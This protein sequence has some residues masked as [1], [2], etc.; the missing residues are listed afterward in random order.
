V[1]RYRMKDGSMVNNPPAKTQEDLDKIEGPLSHADTTMR[2]VRILREDAPELI[3]INFQ[4]HPDCVGGELVSADFPGAVCRRVEE[5]KPGCHC[6]FLNGALGDLVIN[7]R[8]K[9]V[10]RIKDY[11]KAM[12]H[13]EA[14]ADA[15]LQMYDTV[16]STGMC[17]LVTGQMFAHA[18]TKR[19]PSRAQE[20][21]ATVERFEKDG[22]EAVHPEKSKRGSTIADAYMIRTL[23]RM[24][25]DYFDLPVTALVFCGV[26]LLG[27]P[28]EPFNAMGEQIRANS[29]F[30]TTCVCC[31]ANGTYGYYPMASAYEEGGYETGGAM[32]V[33]GGA[34]LLIE[35]A[36][37][38]L[39]SLQ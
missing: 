35:T 2:L 14:I 36:G 1:R 38:L 4:S 6:T 34:E 7:N 22:L 39:D 37:K 21:I 32:V 24:Q 33:K 12:A 19:D 17:G 10:E 11:D 30:P 18:K 20:A 27:I 3:F 28:G 8:M 26:A 16:A 15:A 29:K 31:L 5:C 13:G 9:I 25:T 23:E